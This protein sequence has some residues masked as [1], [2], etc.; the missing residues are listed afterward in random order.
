MQSVMNGVIKVSL[1]IKILHIEH[2]SVEKDLYGQFGGKSHLLPLTLPLSFTHPL[3][4]LF[5]SER[6]GWR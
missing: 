6:A 5:H 3:L 1:S 2:Y 4:S